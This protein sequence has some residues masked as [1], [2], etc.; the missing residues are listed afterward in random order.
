MMIR[1][2]MDS[3]DHVRGSGPERAPQAEHRL[4]MQD[5]RVP[6]CTTLTPTQCWGLPMSTSGLD[7][8]P[9]IKYNKLDD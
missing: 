7:S 5:A 4:C 6:S 2:S 1:G 8:K 9:L 3:D